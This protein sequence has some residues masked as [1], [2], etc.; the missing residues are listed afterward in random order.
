MVPEGSLNESGNQVGVHH[1]YVF[2]FGVF[3]ENQSKY[4]QSSYTSDNVKYT[5]NGFAKGSLPGEYIA[6]PSIIRLIS[7][8]LEPS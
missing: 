7:L 2:L 5:I 8:V 3:D 1:E 4:K 6:L